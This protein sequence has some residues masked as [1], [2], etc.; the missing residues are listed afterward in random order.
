M[1][2]NSFL[3]LCLKKINY[4]IFM[5]LLLILNVPTLLIWFILLPINKKTR[6]EYVFRMHMF[7]AKIVY[8]LFFT[9]QIINKEHYQNVFFKERYIY[10]PNHQTIDLYLLTLVINDNKF[11]Q[12]ITVSLEILLL[13]VPILSWVWYILGYIFVKTKKDNVVKKTVTQLMNYNHLSLYIFPEGKQN[14]HL[15]FRED[16]VKTG[17]FRISLETGIPILPIYH[18]LGLGMCHE[19]FY[20]NYGAQMKI[21]IGD[22]IYPEGKTVDELKEEYIK[23]LRMI[24]N[25]YFT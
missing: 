24:E 16:R 6:N 3:H 21:Y 22:P 1:N 14:S 7:V 25:T 19:P 17:A 15:I 18:N 11:N 10:C 2:H 23:Q 8:N 13:T 5:L 4:I 12:I 9:I 20:L